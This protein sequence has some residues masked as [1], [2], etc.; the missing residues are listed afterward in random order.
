MQEFM[1]KEETVGIKNKWEGGQ[2]LYESILW[3]TGVG[4]HAQKRRFKEG[5]KEN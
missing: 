1:P 3:G 5:I 4:S 2:N